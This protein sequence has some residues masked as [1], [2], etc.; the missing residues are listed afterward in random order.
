[1]TFDKCIIQALEK[2]SAKTVYFCDPDIWN[3][4]YELKYPHGGPA[5]HPMD[6]W[7]AVQ[8]A[9]SRSKVV[10][11]TGYIKTPGFIGIREY[12]HPTYEL[13]EGQ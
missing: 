2:H 6:I 4:I 13:R 1:M 10:V 12:R 8:R 5:K 3:D 7:Q 11:C 9:L